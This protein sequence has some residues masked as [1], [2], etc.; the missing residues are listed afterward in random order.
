MEKSNEKANV[1]T[2]TAAGN[3]YF[4]LS[5]FAD[6]ARRHENECKIWLEDRNEPTSLQP[7]FESNF[8]LLS[9]FVSKFI[10]SDLCGLHN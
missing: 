3:L 9:V 5:T 4:G 6:T 8:N 7:L 10:G 2:G 1:K